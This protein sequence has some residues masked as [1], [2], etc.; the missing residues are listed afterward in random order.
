MAAGIPRGWWSAASGRL[1]SGGIPALRCPGLPSVHP[2][3]FPLSLLVLTHRPDNR[4]GRDGV[5]TRFK[6]P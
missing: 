2:K 3:I 6:T 5:Q 4:D 1:S